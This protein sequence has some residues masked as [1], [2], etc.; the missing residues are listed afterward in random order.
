M[1]DNIVWGA[2]I[3]APIVVLYIWSLIEEKREGE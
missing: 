3:L 1:S 2:I